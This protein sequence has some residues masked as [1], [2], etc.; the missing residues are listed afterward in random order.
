MKKV[1][2]MMVA[3]VLLL[4]SLSVCAYNVTMYAPDGRTADVNFSQVDAWKNVGWYDYKPTVTMYALDGRT[5]SVPMWDVEAWKSVGWYTSKPIDVYSLDGRKLTIPEEHF[6]A[7]AQVGWY[8]EPVAK[9]YSLD[10]R[11]TIAPLKDVSEY[12]KVGWY[13]LHAFFFEANLSQI[14]RHFPLK[15]EQYYAGTRDS[16]DLPRN[17]YSSTSAS[18]VKIYSADFWTKTNECVQVE[19][20]LKDAFPYLK[21]YADSNGRISKGS[22]DTAFRTYGIYGENYRNPQYLLKNI[23]T[24]STE[25]HERLSNLYLYE[26]IPDQYFCNYDYLSF[27]VDF[28]YGGFI[29][30]NNSICSFYTLV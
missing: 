26:D 15:F 7:Y 9:L 11:T 27:T 8:S 2:S 12:R 17:I 4:S 6:Y 13:P 5:A 16:G 1:I 20:D 28:E 30:I 10:G 23:A 3:A 21:L 14:K 25:A 29:N 24:P 18:S 22:I 19:F